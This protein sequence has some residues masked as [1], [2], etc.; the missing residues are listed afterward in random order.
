M[1]TKVAPFSEEINCAPSVLTIEKHVSST[2]SPVLTREEKMS[3]G[4]TVHFVWTVYRINDIDCVK[5]VFG[6]DIRFLFEWE[7]G[8]AYPSMPKAERVHLWYPRLVV[9]NKADD[10]VAQTIDPAH[11]LKIPKAGRV[12]M[13]FRIRGKLQEIYELHDFPFD[14]QD[15]QINL[16]S[17]DDY[18][19]IGRFVP[20]IA[21]RTNSYQNLPLINWN[22]HTHRVF[23]SLTDPNLSTRGREYANIRLALIVKRHYVHYVKTIYAMIFFLTS[24]GFSVFSLKIDQMGERLAA[25]FTLLLT[26]VAYKNELSAQ[27]PRLDYITFLDQYIYLGFSMV[28]LLVFE[29]VIVQKAFDAKVS[30]D[31]KAR[32]LDVDDY[33]SYLWLSLWVGITFFTASMAF[34]ILHRNDVGEPLEITNGRELVGSNGG[35]TGM[36]AKRFRPGYLKPLYSRFVSPAVEHKPQLSPRRRSRETVEETVPVLLEADSEESEEIPCDFLSPA[37]PP[38]KA[39]RFFFEDRGGG[40]RK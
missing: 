31:A 12:R 9:V 38:R 11:D 2:D 16:Q 33:F 28:L 8:N 7:D 37:P 36:F 29:S 17:R 22:Q 13:S 35:V 40:E 39:M 25:N 10:F 26:M 19:T 14:T 21:K 32:V 3:A 20:G 27:I 6:I 4:R 24:C 15:L 34:V 18:R 23:C 1:S 30:D 5:Q